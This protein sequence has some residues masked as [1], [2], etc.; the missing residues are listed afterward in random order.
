MGVVLLLVFLPMV[1]SVALISALMLGDPSPGNMVGALTFI[2]L[3]VGLFL[4][5]IN[6]VHRWEADEVGDR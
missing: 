3:A 5:L 4:V 2:V 1:A 6:L